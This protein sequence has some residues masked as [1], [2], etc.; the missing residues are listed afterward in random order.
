MAADIPLV[1]PVIDA[2]TTPA[3]W[4]GLLLGLGGREVIKGINRLRKTIM[5]DTDDGDDSA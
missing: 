1:Q 3:G 2:L 4:I 5:G